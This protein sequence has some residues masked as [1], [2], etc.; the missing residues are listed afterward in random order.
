MGGEEGELW[1][2][3]SAD[4]NMVRKRGDEKSKDNTVGLGYVWHRGMGAAE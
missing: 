2:K 4:H 3:E 1:E